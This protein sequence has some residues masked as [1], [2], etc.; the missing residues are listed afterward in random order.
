MKKAVKITGITIISLVLLLIIGLVVIVNTIDLNNYKS[1]IST[2]V[3]KATGRT[4]TINGDIQWSFFP[5]LGIK[6]GQT[7]LSNPS[8]FS[9]KTPL[10]NIEEMQISVKL[11]PL[12]IGQVNIGTFV[13]KKPTLHFITTAR[14]KT[15]FD[16]TQP[17]TTSANG[18]NTSNKTSST[19]ANKASDNNTSSLSIDIDNLNISNGLIVWDDRKSKQR[20]Q[21]KNINIAVDHIGL[22][23]THIKLDDIKFTVDKSTL[24]GD[25]DISKITTSPNAKFDLHI[26]QINLDKYVDNQ[27]TVEKPRYSMSPID[28]AYAAPAPAS[29]QAWMSI[30]RQLRANGKLQIDQLRIMKMSL[31]Q[32]KLGLKASDG[33]LHLDPIQ[34]QLYKG[35]YR[36]TIDIDVRGSTPIINAQE[37]LRNVALQPLLKDT[38]GNSTLSGQLQFQAKATTRGLTQQ[39]I[40]K[41]LRGSGQFQVDN[42][43]LHGVDIGQQLLSISQF[44]TLSRKQGLATPPSQR[45]GGQTRF[46]KLSGSAQFSNGI[47]RNNDFIMLSPQF[48]V[49][50]S[51]TVNMLSQAIQYRLKI[52]EGSGADSQ[53][54]TLFDSI[55]HVL[56]KANII[57]L[58]SG[59]LSNMHISPD[60]SMIQQSFKSVGKQLLESTGDTLK[61]TG[62]TLKKLFRF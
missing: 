22:S 24:R 25:V 14:G 13:L 34:A 21:F 36:S 35:S 44:L 51:G 49:T 58:V 5:W 50:G 56:G 31:S 3:Q 10:A 60:W 8:G 28:N 41:N 30:L 37:T 27:T 4:L 38:V 29:S 16:F 23:N 62:K 9:D 48:K 45:R 18:A 7:Q 2:Q 43:A 59:T 39:A 61:D 55:G 47:A 40:F 52:S 6:V 33:K 53:T 57:L 20:T 17:K 1:E 42:G 54:H 12:L 26:D 15:N 46:S 32:V 11:L 19:P